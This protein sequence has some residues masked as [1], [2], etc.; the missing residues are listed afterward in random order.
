M[1]YQEEGRYGVDIPKGVWH[2]LESLAPGS[3]I[4]ECEEGPF[5]EYE[6]EGVM[7]VRC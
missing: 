5:V 3:V 2:K 7:D 1:L 4:F 6:E